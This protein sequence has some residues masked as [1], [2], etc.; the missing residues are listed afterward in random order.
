MAGGSIINARCARAFCWK[1]LRRHA[2]RRR[3]QTRAYQ[4]EKTLLFHFS[5]IAS[6]RRW[7][8][9]MAQNRKNR[10]AQNIALR[11][12]KI[13]N[14]RAAYLYPR[15]GAKG[16]ALCYNQAASGVGFLHLL[17]ACA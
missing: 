15:R 14:L 2:Y 12:A 9:G 17:R 7:L 3:A 13:I 4:C 1:N 10:V 16:I 5:T 8:R 11:G 6:G